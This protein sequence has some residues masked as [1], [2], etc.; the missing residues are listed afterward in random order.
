EIASGERP[1]AFGG[2]GGGAGPTG[3]AVAGGGRG[4]AS[5]RP[6]TRPYTATYA[7]QMENIQDQQGPN[8]FEYG[9]VYKSKDGG[10]TWT[11]IN[12]LN[13]RPM[14][15]SQVRVDPMDDKYV[16]V[17]GV[18]MYRST[19]GGKT[20]RPDAG[21]NVHADQ[22]CM[23][24]DPNDGRH[25]IVGCDGGFY[26]SYDRTRSWDHLN[27]M[28]IGQFYHVAL[29]SKKPYWVFGGLQDNGSW[30]GPSVGLHGPGAVNEEWMSV[31]GGD[32]FV[33]RVDA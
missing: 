32:G 11:R 2:R 6:A 28:A 25:L 31:G 24:I 22:H 33:C 21:R 7:G 20:F 16:Y 23:W 13:P 15:F 17:L 29:S 8:S 5:T 4:G 26:V 30:G 1:A 18:S 14:Y 3:P 9:G 27:H 19:D 10:E 12:S